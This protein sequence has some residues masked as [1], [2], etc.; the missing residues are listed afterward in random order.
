MNPTHSLHFSLPF[1]PVTE[2]SVSTSPMSSVAASITTLANLEGIDAHYISQVTFPILSDLH[3]IQPNE[4]NFSLSPL[5]SPVPP[6]SPGIYL[7]SLT[8]S[9][10][11]S[12]SM[13]FDSFPQ[14]PS[15][16]PTP[17]PISLN[18][19]SCPTPRTSYAALEQLVMDSYQTP[20]EPLEDPFPVI[21]EDL[22]DISSLNPQLPEQE[23]PADSLQEFFMQ[24]EK[25]N[26]EYE[27]SWEDVLEMIREDT[28]SC[29]PLPFS[30]RMHLPPDVS[31]VKGRS[32]PTSGRGEK[33]LKAIMDDEDTSPDT[34]PTLLLEHEI[35][36][37]KSAMEDHSKKVSD[38]VTGVFRPIRVA[39][40]KRR[41]KRPPQQMVVALNK[42]F[43]IKLQE[44]LVEAMKKVTPMSQL[45]GEAFFKH[46]QLIE[47]GSVTSID[48]VRSKQT[49][50][51][52]LDWFKLDK[53]LARLVVMDPQTGARSVISPLVADNIIWW[54][55]CLFAINPQT[56]SM[57]LDMKGERFT[58]VCAH[59]LSALNITLCPQYDTSLY[60][61]KDRFCFFTGQDLDMAMQQPDYICQEQAVVFLSRARY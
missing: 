29:P 53:A 56:R 2:E 22:V 60:P 12:L 27:A 40:P 36:F 14:L 35:F 32:L 9:P 21:Q 10:A 54:L 8:F 20:Q 25:T 49:E 7:P 23:L 57:R 4:D 26:Q 44:E 28:S 6:Q 43:M 13:E 31:I 17:K 1:T 15:F 33:N 34:S 24:L 47:S 48:L 58:E 51:S 18:Y 59:A 11:P 3:T 61:C 38:I 45:F 19:P 30:E 41:F 50:H 37:T 55:S 39:S 46:S 52:A 42:G 16:P 5:N